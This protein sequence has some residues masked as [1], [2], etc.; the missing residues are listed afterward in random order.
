VV[1]RLALA[2]QAS[3]LLR[4]APAAVADGFRAARLGGGGLAYGA[5]PAGIDVAAIV[6]RNRPHSS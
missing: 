4:H 6:E 5:L 1:E 2:L 3:L